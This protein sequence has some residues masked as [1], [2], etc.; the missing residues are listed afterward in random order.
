MPQ[1][2][3]V[4]GAGPLTATISKTNSPRRGWT[5]RF[6]VMRTDKRS[7]RVSQ[8]FHPRD[9]RHFLKLFQVL[10]FTLADDGCLDDDVRLDL[11]RT[12]LMLRE[13]LTAALGRAAED[14]DRQRR[15]S[16]LPFRRK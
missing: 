8:R 4:I 13:N 11:S 3:A 2:Y 6:N 9:V 7:G 14:S 15:N 12:E 5:Y 10:V 1:P 16:K